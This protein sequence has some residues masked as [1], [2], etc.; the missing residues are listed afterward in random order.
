MMN[1]F[2]ILSHKGGMLDLLNADGTAR[3]PYYAFK[4][5]ATSVPRE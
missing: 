5:I 4:A 3:A 1:Q 2:T